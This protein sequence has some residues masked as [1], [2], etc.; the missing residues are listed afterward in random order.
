MQFTDEHKALASNVKNFAQNEIKPFVEDWEK[1][2]H[3]PA[4]DLFKKMGNLD[5]LGIT[6]STEYGGLGLDYSYGMVFA[7]ALGYAADLGVI[8]AIGVQ[9]DMATPALDRFG[10]DE[11]KKEFLTPSILGDLVSAIAVSEPGA[12]SDVASIKTTAQ[13][14]GDDYVING[15]KMWITNAKQADY[16]CTL[17]NTGDG[18]VHKN[19][20]L[21]IIPSDTKGLSVGDKIEKLGQLTSDTAPVYFDNVKVPVENVVGEEN[22]GWT[23][24]KYLLEFERGGNYAAGIQSNIEKIKQIASVERSDTGES[25][26]ED[27]AFLKSLSETEIKAQALLMTEHRI[28]ADIA[29]R[30][31]PGPAS[32]ILKSRGSNLKQEVDM[33]T[34]EAVGYYTMPLQNEARQP[35]SNVEKVG[36]DHALTAF[37]SY[38]NNRAS[39]I[40]GGS[41]EVQRNIMAKFVLG[42]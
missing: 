30:G 12:G 14:T 1:N 16:F 6:K 36:P 4:H 22:D 10:S 25:L 15:Q 28:M 17:V 21:V 34:V 27:D 8:T 7:E 9:T 26:L 41:D 5:F 29:E 19:K 39:T 35:F 11:L 38:L 23:V 20:S 24:A 31:H 37:P 13:K 33:L 2:G 42:L 3:F 40:Y 32:S 18:N